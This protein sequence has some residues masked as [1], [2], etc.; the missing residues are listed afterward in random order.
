MIRVNKELCP[1][2]CQGDVIRDVEYFERAI[3]QEGVLEVHK[4]LFPL[5]VVLTQDC[6]LAQDYTFRTEEQATQD[7]WLISVLLAPAYNAEHVFAGQHL[8][9]IGLATVPINRKKTDGVRLIQNRNPRYHYLDFPPEV[10]LVPSVVDFKHYFSCP[11]AYLQGL[12]KRGNFVCKVAE[13]YREDISQRFSAFLS[14]IG[15]PT[16]EETG[17]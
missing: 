15:L 9:E 17:A 4:V 2:V 8:S 1:R 3:E 13:L 10:E 11:V 6:D 7:K 5:A 16:P 12:K 14:R